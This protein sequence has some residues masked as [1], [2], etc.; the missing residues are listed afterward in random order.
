M[1][2]TQS[3]NER[4]EAAELPASQCLF[5]GPLDD[6][7][8]ACDTLVVLAHGAGANMEHEFMTQMAERLGSRNSGEHDGKQAIAVL[9]FNFPY[10]RSNAIDGKRRPPDRAPKLI[11]DFSL[12]IET[13]REVYKPKRLVVMGKSMG[14]RM[15]AILAGE[16][17]VDGVICLG[18]PFVPPKG[19]EPRLEPVAECQAPL[20][21]IQGERDK[22]GAK[23]QVEPWLAPFKAKLQWLTD[24][25]HSFLPRKSSGTTQS[26]NLDLAV[27]HSIQFIRGLD[28]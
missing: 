13:V 26:A 6:N 16:Q 7:A 2:F 22:F 1:S 27:S 11:K 17:A 10:M 5:S 20:L 18:Y 4:L 19:G 28:A 3:L 25:D 8:L 14:G 15:A 12:L 21:V 23:G 24:G 9:R